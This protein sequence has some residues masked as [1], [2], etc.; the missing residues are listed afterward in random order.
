VPQSSASSAC[1]SACCGGAARPQNP[2]LD[3]VQRGRKRPVESISD[4]DRHGTRG[5]SDIEYLNPSI[6]DT[7]R[8][9]AA[10]MRDFPSL[11]QIRA[12]IAIM[13]AETAIDRRNRALVAFAILTG[14]RDRAMVSLSLGH[15]DITRAPPVVRQDPNSV[16][17]KFA[18][19]IVTYFFPVGDDFAA[20]VRDWIGELQRVH[21]FGPAD[22]LFP[23]TCTGLGAEGAFAPVGI[24]REHWSDASPVR[25]IFRKAFEGAG[26]P[27]F[28]PH[29]FRHTLGHLHKSAFQ[30]QVF[31]MKHGYARVSS[32]AQD[33]QA[34]VEA[35]RAG[36]CEKSSAKSNRARPGTVARSL[37]SS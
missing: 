7:A 22:P 32:K 6:K 14:I 33:Y 34:Q 11:E 17:T 15:T 12:A 29:S 30:K 19:A 18:K 3:P 35:L 8:A 4:R 13:P 31:G 5:Q 26:L 16:D 27:Y 25:G 23:R 20:I 9:K 21:L 1:A 24:E 28:A 10:K 37:P 2:V 36:G